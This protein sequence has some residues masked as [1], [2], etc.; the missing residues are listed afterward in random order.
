[1]PWPDQYLTGKAQLERNLARAAEAEQA[2]RL[3]ANG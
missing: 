2:E 3:E 1:M